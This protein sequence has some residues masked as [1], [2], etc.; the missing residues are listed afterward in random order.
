MADKSHKYIYVYKT[1]NLVNGK[2]YIGVRCTNYINDGYIGCGIKSY[3]EAKLKTKTNNGFCFAVVKHGYH[4]FKKEII[5]FFESREDAYDFESSI[6]TEKE[7]CDSNCYNIALGGLYNRRVSK[8]NKFK[9][10]W[11]KLYTD[12]LSINQICKKYKCNYA[13]VIRQ[14][15]DSNKRT[16]VFATSK[17]IRCLNNDKIYNSLSECSRLMF[18]GKHLSSISKVAL[19]NQ[20]SLKGFNFEYV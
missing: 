14:I 18:E 6:V 7:V 16:R 20:K 4:N 9:E 19:G 1:T 3:K 10:E 5:K 8:Y 2:Y 12:G 17:K 15:D 13:A 11:N